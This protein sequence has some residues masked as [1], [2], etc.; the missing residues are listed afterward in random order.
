MLFLALICI[1]SLEFLCKHF[2]QEQIEQ[3]EFL[4]EKKTKDDNF[5]N[6]FHFSSRYEC[7]MC[8]GDLRDVYFQLDSSL[9]LDICDKCQGV[10]YDDNKL[11]K[12]VSLIK[13]KNK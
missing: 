6:L 9:R 12:V 5:K 4:G 10:F 11:L 7:P 13:E 2:K 3:L 8:N 1:K